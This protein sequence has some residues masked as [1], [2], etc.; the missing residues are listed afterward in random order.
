MNFKP[1]GTG[2]KPPTTN[3]APV[4]AKMTGASKVNLRG[5]C[6]MNSATMRAGRRTTCNRY[7][8]R[9]VS[10]YEYP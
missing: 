5:K 8:L 7:I 10:V 1:S 2:N 4:T 9:I 6:R 3:D